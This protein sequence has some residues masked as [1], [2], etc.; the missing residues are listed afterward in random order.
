[1]R[2]RI[3]T[4]C[5]LIVRGH[6]VDLFAISPPQLAQGF[7]SLSNWAIPSYE[8]TSLLRVSFP[9]IM[10]YYSKIFNQNHSMESTHKT[11]GSIVLD[12]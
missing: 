7:Y 12:V 5:K 10:A 11:D 1:M 9:P 8:V 4:V 6:E 2:T 3:N